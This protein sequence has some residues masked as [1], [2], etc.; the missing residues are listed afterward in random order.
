MTIEKTWCAVQSPGV[1]YQ[2][3]SL[4]HHLR[5]YSSDNCLESALTM[6]PL[7]SK[8]NP[9]YTRIGNSQLRNMRYSVADR[10]C[11]ALWIC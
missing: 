2:V 9:S 6:N 3:T 11:G 10:V 5:H 1:V 4:L 7:R 8:S